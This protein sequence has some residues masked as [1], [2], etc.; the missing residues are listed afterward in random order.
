MQLSQNKGSA[1]T[2]RQGTT[3]LRDM[4]IKISE[5]RRNELCEYDN[6]ENYK[7]SLRKCNSM[8]M[9]DPCD[10]ICAGLLA[11]AISNCF[12]PIA[13]MQL[14]T[15]F[16]ASRDVEG[17]RKGALPGKLNLFIDLSQSSPGK[18]LLLMKGKGTPHQVRRARLNRKA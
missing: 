10:A 2:N 13:I 18:T 3:P 7:A 16:S 14:A 4:L 11:N 9:T 6:K 15:A 8:T 1:Q 17:L 12:V 5:V